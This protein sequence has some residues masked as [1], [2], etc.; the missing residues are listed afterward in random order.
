M[1]KNLHVVLDELLFLYEGYS[2]VYRASTQPSRLQAVQQLIK[3]YQYN[4]KD[5]AVR[6]SLIE[7]SGSLAIVATAIY[8]HINNP[9]VDLGKAL[10]MLAI[11]DIGEL[12]TG[13][14]MV[15]TK[16]HD[17]GKYEQQQALQLLP[18]YYHNLYWEV[19]ERCTDTAKFA[20]AID[21]ITPDLVDL[22]TPP[23]TIVERYRIFTNKSPEEI[24]PMIK[25]FK[26][27]YMVWNP[28]LSKLHLLLLE[29]LEK[30]LQP[31]YS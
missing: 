7:H 28:F 21:K 10:I 27:P 31:F 15:F 23:E 2:K 13:D 6:E 12:I 11:H 14:E 25:E 22:M 3:D 19:E 29:R 20:K 24:V 9:K 17:Q 4:C 26:H 5:T 16:T 8:P 30:K 1:D 18:T